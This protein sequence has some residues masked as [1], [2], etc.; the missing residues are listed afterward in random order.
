MGPSQARPGTAGSADV[1][2]GTRAVPVRAERACAVAAAADA[3]GAR[4]EDALFAVG[5]P[6]GATARAEPFLPCCVFGVRLD[7]ATV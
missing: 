6:W 5:D 7:W 3:L 4:V 1:I 2:D